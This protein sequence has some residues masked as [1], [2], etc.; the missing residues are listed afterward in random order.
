M[1]DW[2][3][4]ASDFFVP[5]LDDGMAYITPPARV[6]TRSP[7]SRV[8][9]MPSSDTQII[10]RK[11]RI[12]TEARWKSPTNPPVFETLS[13]VVRADK[14]IVGQRKIKVDGKLLLS[15]AAG[16]RVWRAVLN[17]LDAEAEES[18]N[19]SI[20]RRRQTAIAPMAMAEGSA[21]GL[22]FVVDLRNGYNFYHF[23]TEGLP[24]LAVIRRTEATA[25]IFVH[26]PSI[27][28]LK[29]FLG[30]FIRDIYP[31]L[32]PRIVFTDEPT[33]HESVRLV[34][35]HRHYLYQSSDP[36]IDAAL[37]GLDDAD[38]WKNLGSDRASRKFL[39]K[40]TFDTGMRF[41]R[42]DALSRVAALPS[43]NRPR[44]LW[45][46]RDPDNVDFKSRPNVGEAE[47]LAE[48]RRR[49]FHIAYLEQLSPLEQIALIAGADMIVGPHGAAFAHMM[50][51][52][53]SA[54]VVEI[55]TPQTQLHRWGD[56]LGNA[57]VSACAYSTVFADVMGHAE[58][59][60]VPSI[61]TGHHGIHIGD[62][63]AQRILDHIDEFSPRFA[64]TSNSPV[65]ASSTEQ[66]MPAESNDAPEP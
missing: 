51:A 63:A 19:A 23:L 24:Q 18:L 22:P 21:D 46:G 2:K 11:M 14:V 50:F 17:K 65:P 36:T 29:G 54:L 48:L 44:R 37:I 31:D 3:F 52:Q 33:R 55:G 30:S 38:P 1:S 6:L 9:Q 49:D 53:R 27:R 56:F 47:L 59:E 28:E 43:G 62:A 20:A 66:A 61:E 26:M 45:I 41:L 60:E 16:D 64:E 42:E 57:H 15:A 34:Y 32:M 40:S 5:G 35:N 10:N 12:R 58:A 7:P 25:P 39:L 4:T 13:T 8:R